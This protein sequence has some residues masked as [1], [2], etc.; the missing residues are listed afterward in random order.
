[1]TTIK[2]ADAH[3]RRLRQLRGAA[4]IRPVTRAV[5]AAAQDL[6]VDASLS[7]TKGAVSGAKHV[8]SKPGE[9]PNSD[10]H[11]LARSIEATPTGPL[12]AET[13][14]NAPYAAIQE[15]G[16]TIEHPGGTPYFVGRDGKIRFVSKQGPGAFHGLPVTKPHSI[17]L[18]ERPYMR[19]A[20]QRSRPH[21]VKRVVD[22][23]NKVIRGSGK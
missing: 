12:K 16:G 3:K 20:A 15:F 5:F 8:P 22:A 14:A 10:S 21:A 2:G 1:M 7:I 9:P 11:V 4:M 17:T 19:P 6:A 23:V 18:E 13:S